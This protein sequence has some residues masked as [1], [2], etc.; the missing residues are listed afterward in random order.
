MTTH[1]DRQRLCLQQ[2]KTG[3]RME[4]RAGMMSLLRRIDL[5]KS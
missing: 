5:S 3:P 4:A 1:R 2:R